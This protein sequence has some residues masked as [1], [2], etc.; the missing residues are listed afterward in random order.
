MRLSRMITLILLLA[1]GLHVVTIWLM[2]RV[3]LAAVTTSM[4]L[5]DMPLNQLVH[6]DRQTAASSRV[7]RPS[8]D[9]LYSICHYDLSM[10]SV[11]V[12][13]DRMP[14]SYWSISGYS[15]NTDNFFVVNDRVAQGRPLDIVLSHAGKRNSGADF[16]SP[17]IRGIILL[18][19]V[20]ENDNALPALEAFRQTAK[21]EPVL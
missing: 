10:G 4:Q 15:A 12:A 13:T 16:Y 17:S 2:P 14:D 8:P 7:V 18:R 3:L 20:I 19:M 11:H 1:V 21:C 6:S 5:D 9:L